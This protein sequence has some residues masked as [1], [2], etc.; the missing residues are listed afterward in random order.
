MLDEL[1]GRRFWRD[2]DWILLLF[3]VL[4]SG[5]GLVEIYSSTL[6]SGTENFVGRQAAWVLIGITALFAVAAVDYRVLGENAPLIYG[7]TIV[8][9]IAVLLFGDTVSGAQSWF[10]FGPA[11]IQPSEPAKLVI[12]VMLARYFSRI[13]QRYLTIGQILLAAGICGLPVVL[14]ALQPDLGTAMTFI[15]ILVF[16]LFVR[17]VRP[18]VLVGGGLVV[19]M[20]LPLTWFVLEDHQKDRMVTFVRPDLDPLGRGYQIN[21]SKIAIGSGGMWG[22]G[23]FEGSQNQLGFLP[24]RH[25]DFIFSVVAEE[26]GFVGVLVTLGLLL[27]LISRAMAVAM[28]PPDTFGL[29]LVVGVVGLFVGHIIVNVGMVIGFVPSTGIPLPFLSYGGSSLLTAFMAL[30]LIASVRRCRYVN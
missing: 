2:F 13:E 25:T 22:K 7:A 14:V 4:L 29:F 6:S 10:R 27:A 9:L 30:G 15:P 16:G 28:A 17:G 5:I 19:I 8:V 26:M 3:A 23:L 12:A 11:S 21:Q 1:G 18:R 24:T 20:L